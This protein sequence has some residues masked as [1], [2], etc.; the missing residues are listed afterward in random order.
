MLMNEYNVNCLHIYVC[1]TETACWRVK[2]L[3]TASWRGEACAALKKTT[4]ARERR[5]VR[6][7]RFIDC[8]EERPTAT[9]P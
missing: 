8:E 9:T 2:W 5:C 3:P 4:R 1:M 7:D 6:V